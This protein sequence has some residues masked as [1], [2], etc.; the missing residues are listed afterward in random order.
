MSLTRV[1]VLLLAVAA[2]LVAVAIPVAIALL[3]RRTGFTFSAEGLSV[4]IASDVGTQ[5]S[6]LLRDPLLGICG[7]PDYL[8]ESDIGG[9]KLLVPLE[10]KPTR[11][12]HRLYDSDRMQIGAY[13][14]ALRGTFPHRASSV[15]YVRYAER[16]FEVHLTP[17]LER[18]VGQIAA[19]VRQGR[20]AAVLHRSHNIGARCRACPMRP[21]CDEAL[22]G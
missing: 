6:I 20:R 18:E 4:V 14:L 5:Q 7:K 1:V 11:H 21:R 2:V 10:V 12:S 9:R 17:A 13:L 8:L 15:G 16:T 19:A 22:P 3:R